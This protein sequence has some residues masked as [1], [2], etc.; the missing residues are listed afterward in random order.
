[1]SNKFT[2]K[3]YHIALAVEAILIVLVGV[4][5]AVGGVAYGSH[6]NQPTSTQSSFDHVFQPTGTPTPSAAGSGTINFA[7]AGS[8]VTPLTDNNADQE[9]KAAGSQP[10]VIYVCGPNQR[11]VCPL[12]DKAI[13]AA[14]DA[15][16]GKVAFFYVN[17]EDA[18]AQ[19]VAN[20]LGVSSA[21]DL[22]TIL[23][24]KDAS[25]PG[26]LPLPGYWSASELEKIISG[27]VSGAIPIQT[28][29]PAA[30]DNATPGAAATA[31]PTTS[32]F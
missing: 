28:P 20:A 5:A 25:Q 32:G 31:A 18:N 13:A 26:S 27:V 29:P 4:L 7:A 12:E 9:V 16:K 11:D 15:L 1:M 30:T 22:P 21:L 23:V 8:L 24:I 6:Q 3:A 14:A 10:I 2:P 17:V 19:N